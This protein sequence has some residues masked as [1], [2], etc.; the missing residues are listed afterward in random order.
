MLPDLGLS[1]S[2]LFYPASAEVGPQGASTS[3]RPCQVAAHTSF[4]QYFLARCRWSLSQKPLPLYF[5]LNRIPAVI[6]GTQLE[7]AK[8]RASIPGTKENPAGMWVGSIMGRMPQ[9]VAAGD[10]AGPEVRVARGGNAETRAARHYMQV[11]RAALSSQA[12]G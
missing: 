6:L 1:I 2:A 4:A 3:C 9:R 10:C 7:L 5:L 11:H 8:S 12:A